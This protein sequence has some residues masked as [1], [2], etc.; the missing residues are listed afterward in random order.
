M[1]NISEFD[2]FILDSPSFSLPLFYKSV[3]LISH[4][5]V[6]LMQDL[7]NMAVGRIHTGILKYFR[8]VGSSSSLTTQTLPDP[9]SLL[10]EMVPAKAI[11]LDIL[12]QNS[13]KSHHTDK[14]HR[15]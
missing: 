7:F 6:N 1:E 9:D 13:P 10:S 5:P 2:K 3:K 4:D 11:K 12:K 8:P 15:I 14:D